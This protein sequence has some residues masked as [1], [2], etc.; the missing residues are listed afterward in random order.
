M[1]HEDRVLE[2]LRKNKLNKNI[3][4]V[5]FEFFDENA[6][7]RFGISQKDIDNFC[8]IKNIL[9]SSE[10]CFKDKLKE[11]SEDYIKDFVNRSLS[12]FCNFEKDSFREFVL[13]SIK[14]GFHI[15][16]DEKTIFDFY[17]VQNMLSVYVIDAIRKYK[18][19]L[20]IFGLTASFV[21]FSHFSSEIVSLAY[22]EKILTNKISEVYEKSLK[23]PLSG[24]YNRN[25][26]NDIKNN[27]F[28][29]FRR[30]KMPLSICMMDIDNFKR[31]NDTHGHTIGDEVL[32]TLGSS[33]LKNTRTSDLA[34]RWGG[35][36]F[37]II[38]THTPINKAKI[39]CEKLIKKIRE[40]ELHTEAGNLKFTVSMG[41]T[42]LKEED[43]SL[44]TTIDR[45]DKA[46][47]EA[48]RAGKNR[49]ELLI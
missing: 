43:E 44:E 23:D 32:K 39:A 40:I 20:D 6:L 1:N 22:Y 24:L 28:S 48:K 5:F 25:K 14:I 41:L 33:V 16:N 37:M 13:E 12:L 45:A 3:A 35:E 30:Y 15:V 18:D 21:K 36:E 9:L 11:I 34:F 31:I 19:V 49:I 17:K 46:L 4:Q 26:F 8:D 7:T 47:Y 42:E 2:L 10:D 38:F 29:R 27:E